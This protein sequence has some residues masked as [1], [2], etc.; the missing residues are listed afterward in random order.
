MIYCNAPWVGATFLPDGKYAPCCAYSDRS[1]DSIQEMINDVGGKFLRGEIPAGC[2]GQ[3]PRETYNRLETD[4]KTHKIKFL[5]FRN[6][7]LCNMKCRSCG[8]GFSSAWA[9]EAKIHKIHAHQP[10]SIAELDLSEC[11]SVYFAG[12]EPLMNPQHYEILEK[13][14]E[15]G[16]HP[17]IMYNTNI[18]VLNY[19]HKHV[20]DYWP[21]LDKIKINVSIDAVGQYAEVVRSGT[22]WSVIEENLAWLRS[23]QNI[24]MSISPVISAINIWFIDSFFEYFDWIDEPISFQPILANVDSEFGLMC[25]PYI[26]RDDIIKSLSSTKFSKHVTIQRA[27]EVLQQQNF[28][29]LN[30]Y[31]FLAQQLILDNYRK[32]NWFDLLPK[33]HQVYK[34]VFRV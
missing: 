28:D 21:K 33:K 14:I 2:P 9:S 3:C 7:N 25:I 23:Q 17:T 26:F 19:K 31:R 20:K 8:P 22:D 15:Q 10:I 12:G 18:S 27:I 13:L 34:E 4:Y 5:D 6:D 30:W 32:E 24:S 11:E 16:S 29:Q 1:Y